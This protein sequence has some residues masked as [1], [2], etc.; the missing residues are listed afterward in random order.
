[1]DGWRDFSLTVPFC[2]NY[3]SM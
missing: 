1:M 2:L 3:S